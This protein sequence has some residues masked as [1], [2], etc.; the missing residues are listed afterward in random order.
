MG[1]PLLMNARF[2]LLFAAL[3]LVLAGCSTIDSRI[4]EK[5]AEFNSLPPAAQAQIRQG[6]IAVGYTPDM[7]YMAIGRPDEVRE[8]SDKGGRET[9]WKYNSYYDRYEGTVR[10]GY[11]RWVYWDPRIR[12]YR[13]YFEPRYANV[14]STEK[15]TYF[16]ITFRDGKVTTIEETKQ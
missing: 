16:R 6:I 7:V 1:C 14:Y 4:R 2:R 8:R 10:A 13:V 12:A 5:E 3:L 9:V 15:E 11:R